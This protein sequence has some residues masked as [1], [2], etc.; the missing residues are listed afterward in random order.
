MPEK[1][2]LKDYLIEYEHEGRRY[3]VS[4]KAYSLQD[5]DAK[6]ES[7]KRSGWVEGVAAF[8]GGTPKLPPRGG[9]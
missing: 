3:G 4:F 2:K 5:A 7:I 6:L 1:A 9:A 8:G